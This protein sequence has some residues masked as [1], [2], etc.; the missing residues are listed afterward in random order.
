MLGGEEEQTDCGV[1]KLKYYFIFHRFHLVSHS[2]FPIVVHVQFNYFISSRACPFCLGL[3]QFLFICSC[4]KA[5]FREASLMARRF[6]FRPSCM[7]NYFHFVTIS[8]IYL[9]RDDG[10]E[11]V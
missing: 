2:G 3:C 5:D 8:H 4:T 11:G 6:F 10:G 7:I 9:E 1:E